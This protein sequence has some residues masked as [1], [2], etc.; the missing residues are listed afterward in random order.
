M[1][2]KHLE[3]EWI[4]GLIA[5]IASLLPLAAAPK[6]HIFRGAADFV[7]ELLRYPEYPAVAAEQTARRISFWFSEKSALQDRL[8]ILEEENVEGS[9]LWSMGSTRR[10][11]DE[12]DRFYGYGRVTLR[13][14]LSWWS[15]VRINRGTKDGVFSGTPVLHNGYLAGRVS[16]SEDGYSWVELLTSSSLMVPVVIE[17]TRDLGVVAGDG[18]GG[19]WLLYVPEGR[20]LAGGMEVKTAMVS[21]ALPPGIPVGKLS[22]ESRKTGGAYLEWK[23]I[24]GADL[25][26]LYALQ[27]LGGIPGENVSPGETGRSALP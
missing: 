5:I 2:E 9:G 12:L 1:T 24:P 20:S 27:V 8:D 17:E 7:G 19:V 10:L 15:E 26:K 23:V 18:E 16:S 21:E 22:S 25:S 13:E 4:H 11:Q 6:R 14:P 3:K